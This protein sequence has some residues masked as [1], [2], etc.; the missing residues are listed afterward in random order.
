MWG[1]CCVVSGSRTLPGPEGGS[2]A[3]FLMLRA[4]GG[5]SI[6]CAGRLAC[7]CHTTVGNI[8]DIIPQMYLLAPERQLL[9]AGGRALSG[10]GR[11]S[12]LE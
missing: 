7:P 1:C 8:C 5:K 10:R 9:E 4:A 2:R 12:L 6:N 3:V 11:D